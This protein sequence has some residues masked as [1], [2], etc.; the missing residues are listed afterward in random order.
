MKR[1]TVLALVVLAGCASRAPQ[2]A[3]SWQGRTLDEVVA[4]WGPPTASHT[5]DDGRR[6]ISYRSRDIIT[7]FNP[8]APYQR[9]VID[10]DTTFVADAR[11][12]ILSSSATGGR[13]GCGASDR[14][15][16]G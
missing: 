13:A 15:P 10:C 8:Y 2:I 16:A 3:A 7:G 12:V 5:F 1:V 4:V 6:V 14:P 9:R 11:G